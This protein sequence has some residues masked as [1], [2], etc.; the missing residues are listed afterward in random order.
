MQ[1]E[2]IKFRVT[3]RKIGNSRAV[4]LSASLY[5]EKVLKDGEQYEVI[6]N[7]IPNV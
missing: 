5:K 1:K 7:K 2:L 4:V 6:I 3:P